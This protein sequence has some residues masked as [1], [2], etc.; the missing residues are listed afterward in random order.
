VLIKCDFQE[1]FKVQVRSRVSLVQK[2]A[3]Q[4]QPIAYISEET[5]SPR[6]SLFDD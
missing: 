4:E 1:S 5:P 6:D 2:A 3:S